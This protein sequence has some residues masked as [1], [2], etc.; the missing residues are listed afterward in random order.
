MHIL[1]TADECDLPLSYR[2][3]AELALRSLEAEI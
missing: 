3:A 2:L 1:E